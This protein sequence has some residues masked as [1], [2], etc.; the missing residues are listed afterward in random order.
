MA[1]SLPSND[2]TWIRKK[3]IVEYKSR[4]QQRQRQYLIGDRGAELPCKRRF[5]ITIPIRTDDVERF[6]EANDKYFT[7]LEVPVTLQQARSVG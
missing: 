6:E 3:S 5:L 4:G 2:V 7:N 1:E